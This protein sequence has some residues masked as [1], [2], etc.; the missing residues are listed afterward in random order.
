MEYTS[1]PK[2][3]F[4]TMNALENQIQSQVQIQIKNAQTAITA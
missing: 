1:E 4:I 3:H 2:N